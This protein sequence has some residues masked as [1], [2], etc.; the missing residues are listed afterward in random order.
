MQQVV[1]F[2]IDFSKES[3]EYLTNDLKK[4]EQLV[5]SNDQLSPEELFTAHFK[6]PYD[7]VKID[8]SEPPTVV[9]DIIERYKGISLG[10]PE[11]WFQLKDRIDVHIR[12]RDI[13]IEGKP[14]SFL[15]MPKD[16]TPV[17][18]I[19]NENYAKSS[20][21]TVYCITNINYGNP[22]NVIAFEQSCDEKLVR[23]QGNINLLNAE[24]TRFNET[25]KTEMMNK[26]REAKNA[27][28]EKIA[29]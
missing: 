15:L 19:V 18:L 28:A 14:S 26:I 29:S 1:L 4:V 5:E 10:L 8:V 17:R 27:M 12:Q 3:S 6:S 20:T 16:G 7:L 21:V 24:I 23:I 11:E 22:E 2:G 9:Q 25:Y 13:K